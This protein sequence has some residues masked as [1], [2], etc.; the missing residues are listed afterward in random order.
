[1]DNYSLYKT[2][3]GF[4][5]YEVNTYGIIKSKITG[6]IINQAV[7]GNGYYTCF[8]SK[9]FNINNKEQYRQVQLLVHRLT[10]LTWLPIDDA[11]L[12]QVNHKNGNKLDN[13]VSNLEWVTLVENIEHAINLGLHTSTRKSKC[14][15]R[16]Y[17]TSDVVE[18]DNVMDAVRYMGYTS[19]VSRQ[20]LSPRT[21]GKLI[22]DKYE[23]R[24]DDDQRPWFYENRKEKVLSRYMLNVIYNDG[25][26]K[27]FFST[28]DIIKEFKLYGLKA[29]SI[30]DL[31]NYLVDT[32]KEY[33]FEYIDSYEL[34][35][36]SRNKGGVRINENKQVILADNDKIIILPSLRSAAD[37][38]G[39]DRSV[40]TKAIDTLT[41]IGEYIL[42]QNDLDL[43]DLYR[44]R[45]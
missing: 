22:K 24:W 33:K 2:I 43:I 45:E 39:V 10:A 13:R 42:M 20:A 21:F 8:L 44:L 16:N 19:P 17:Y 35:I 34:D 12:F 14:R 40:I 41:P 32:F 37:Y 7:G 27:E 3:P 9:K 36:P 1:M 18:F 4:D 38:L 23:I 29:R 15:I 25:T 11:K 30:K 6:S 31:Y 5:D 26:N 28:K